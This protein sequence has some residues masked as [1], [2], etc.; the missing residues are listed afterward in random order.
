MNEI[1]RFSFLE[2]KR[3]D[4]AFHAKGLWLYSKI[5]EEPYGTIIGSSNFG[6][7]SVHRDLESQIIMLTSNKKLK[8]Q[9]G[10]EINY[11]YQYCSLA[12]ADLLKRYIPLWVKAF[13]YIFRG[14]F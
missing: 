13:V 7:R 5:S 4:W 9:M 11:L 2:Y 10:E 6:E 8:R 14:F 12:E 1:K 3:N